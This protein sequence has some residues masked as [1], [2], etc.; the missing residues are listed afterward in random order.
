MKTVLVARLGVIGDQLIAASVLPLLKE[1]GYHITYM[2]YKPYAEIVRN[3]PAIDILRELDQ[4]V[5]GDAVNFLNFWRTIGPAYDR[6]IHLSE[7]LE[8][9]L[10]F[11][12]DQMQF[13]WDDTA[14]RAISN[15]SYLERTHDLAGV[16]YRFGQKFWPTQ[17]EDDDAKELIEGYRPSRLYGL[18]V[19][20]SNFDKLYPNWPQVVARILQEDP[21]ARF[22]LL[23]A[24]NKR[25][26]ALIQSVMIV[27][28][29]NRGTEEAARLRHSLKWGIRKTLA[30]TRRLDFLIGPD[31]GLHWVASHEPV[32]QVVLLSHASPKN[33]T[34][35]WTMTRTLTARDVSCWPC[36]KLHHGPETCN[37]D[38]ATGAARCIASITVDDV[39]DATV[40]LIKEHRSP[41]PS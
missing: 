31:T 12:P 3:N 7:S 13:W 29:E 41:C 30:V 19:A 5:L 33:I 40:S 11:Y 23:G 37:I 1:Q 21:T 34:H 10:I 15:V 16:P 14:R 39:V 8:R 25:D 9:T 6:V 17:E 18:V 24:D 28:R 22:F 2:V 38:K 4:G 20:G 32:R 36:H 35:S 26:Q 27:I